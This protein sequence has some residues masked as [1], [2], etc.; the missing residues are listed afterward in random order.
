MILVNIY[1]CSRDKYVLKEE[2]CPLLAKTSMIY[3][4]TK[5]GRKLHQYICKFWKIL[6]K[7]IIY[8]SSGK[9]ET[10]FFLNRQNYILGTNKRSYNPNVI[11]H[12]DN[13]AILLKT[14]INKNIVWY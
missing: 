9:F 3:L 10:T 7:I 14:I 5:L 1:K 12:T 13:F 11:Y 2:I 4:I 8:P 6:H